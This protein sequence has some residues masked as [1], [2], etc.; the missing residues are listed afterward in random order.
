MRPYSRLR[1]LITAHGDSTA[2]A[3]SA[4]YLGVTAL[5]MRL[6]N[7]AEWRLSEMYALMDRYGVPHSELS[8]VFPKNGANE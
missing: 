7:R 6:N 1:G 8:S 3:A 4:A 5:S 2:D